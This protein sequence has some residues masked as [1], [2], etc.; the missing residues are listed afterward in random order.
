[1]RLTPKDQIG[2]IMSALT[3]GAADYRQQAA[4]QTAMGNQD[5]VRY[6]TTRAIFLVGLYHH[7][8][9]YFKSDEINNPDFCWTLPSDHL[10]DLAAEAASKLHE[11]L[12]Y[13]AT[14]PGEA[15]IAVAQQQRADAAAMSGEKAG[16]D[17]QEK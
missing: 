16:G 7:L 4:Q 17:G 6:A 3:C 11:T 15:Q 14:R 13:D 8:D 2:A 12:R 1:M 10:E 9:Q 5:G